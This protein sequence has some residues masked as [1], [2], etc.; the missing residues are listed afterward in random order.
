MDVQTWDSVGGSGQH[1]KE[2]VCNRECVHKG[3]SL[4]QGLRVGKGHHEQG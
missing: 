3:G 1:A 4:L 2:C